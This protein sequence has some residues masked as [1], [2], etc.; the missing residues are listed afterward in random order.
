LQGLPERALSAAA[1]CEIGSLRLC[2]V[3]TAGLSWRV[4]GN[5]L[6]APGDVLIGLAP[7][8]VRTLQNAWMQNPT[9][10]QGSQKYENHA[11]NS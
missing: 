6:V 9:H 5:A 7:L 4:R 11:A 10:T 3:T 1:H 2:A 8:A